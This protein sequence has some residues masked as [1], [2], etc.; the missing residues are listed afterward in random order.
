M[1]IPSFFCFTVYTRGTRNAEGSV[2]SLITSAR[3]YMRAG[4]FRERAR[5]LRLYGA[6]RHVLYAI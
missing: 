6:R 4:L 5:G 3:C 2:G 1:A